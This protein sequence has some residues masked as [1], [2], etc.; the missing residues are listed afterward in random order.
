M[1]ARLAFG[2]VR[3][4]PKPLKIDNCT[5]TFWSRSPWYNW[6]AFG[7]GTGR[8]VGWT[9]VMA[10]VLVMSNLAQVAAVYTYVL[11]GLDDAAD[12][13]SAK[14]A[15][16][17]TDAGVELDPCLD[18]KSAVEIEL[19]VKVVAVLPSEPKRGFGRPLKRG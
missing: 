5:G 14:K 16:T 19:V 9:T 15:V 13:A 12:D 4:C 3:P 10:C 8:M 6:K 17:V 7:I 1:A 2:L 11:F 18:G